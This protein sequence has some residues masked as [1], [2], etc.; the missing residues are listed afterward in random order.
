METDSI[1]DIQWLRMKELPVRKK[2]F[3]SKYGLNTVRLKEMR[4]DQSRKDCNYKQLHSIVIYCTSSAQKTDE[5]AVVLSI[6]NR[7][8]I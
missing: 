6:Y 2:E 5:V 7:H 1:D 4:N 3:R 8:H